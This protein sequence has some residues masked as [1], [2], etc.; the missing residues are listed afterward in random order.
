MV[1][2]WEVSE[3]KRVKIENADKGEKVKRDELVGW[4]KA[5]DVWTGWVE[6]R[7]A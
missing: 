3:G 7:W 4:L 5:T 1:G 2:S 6:R